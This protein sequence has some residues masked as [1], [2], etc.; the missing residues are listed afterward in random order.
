MLER[1]REVAR[2]QGI[3]N[4]EW[5]SGDVLPLPFADDSF[6]I[7]VSRFAFHH[8]ESPRAVLAE[9]RRVCRPGGRVV[10][11]DLLASPDPV[12]A[13]AFHDMEIL[14]DPSHVRCLTLAELRDLFAAAGLSGPEETSYRMRLELEAYLERSFPAPGD[15]PRIRRMFE[16]A[17]ADDGFGL[18][19]R[20]RGDRIL[21]AFPIA[22]LVATR[23]LASP[24]GR[25]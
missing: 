23:P 14:R 18:D 20:R 6:S 19:V 1:A 3:A 4:V 7:V 13:R 22:I 17:A 24:A 25:R 5:R 11:V 12:K 9:M 21:F 16:E 8:F 2:E 15:E 10:V